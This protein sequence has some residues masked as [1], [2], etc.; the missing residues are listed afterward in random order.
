MTHHLTYHKDTSAGKFISSYLHL[1]D[2]GELERR[3]EGAGIR[4]GPAPRLARQRCVT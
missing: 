2:S 3:E 1:Y 4:R